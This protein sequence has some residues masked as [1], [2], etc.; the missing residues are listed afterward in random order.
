LKVKICGLDEAGRGPLAGP[1]VAAA[2]ILNVKFRMYNLQLKDSKKLNRRQREF[3]YDKLMDSGS[4]IRTEIISTRLINNR[5]IGWANKEIFKK[6]IKQTEADKYIVDG[7][8]KVR[9]RG[10]SKKIKSVVR[11]DG[12]RKCVM[13]ASI[14]AKVTRDRLM[15]ELHRKFPNYNWK[16]NAGYGTKEHIEALK[17][18]GETRYHR[19]VF[20]RTALKRVEKPE[21]RRV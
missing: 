8:L 6:L 9:V 21:S 13:A 12:T 18:F 20:V 2:A 11:A 17:R 16:K 4:E 15:T 7:L 1:L 3:F 5:G 19:S 10:L 14:I